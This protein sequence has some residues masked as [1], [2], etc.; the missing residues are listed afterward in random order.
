MNLIL[1]LRKPYYKARNDDTA[2]II[3]SVGI[4][5]TI[6]NNYKIYDW[7]I[8]PSFLETIKHEKDS[9]VLQKYKLHEVRILCVMV[10]NDR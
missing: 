5:G 8:C 9:H 7:M 10:V 2:R 1:Y 6:F 3:T 4:V